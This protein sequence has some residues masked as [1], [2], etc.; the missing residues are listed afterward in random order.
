MHLSRERVQAQEQKSRDE[1]TQLNL[2]HAQLLQLQQEKAA[3]QL[4]EAD[5]R[6]REAEKKTQEA[7]EARDKAMQASIDD[8]NKRIEL[9]VFDNPNYQAV[10]H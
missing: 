10:I 4:A 9:A 7:Q 3:I 6:A 8:K 1:L 5:R 2:H